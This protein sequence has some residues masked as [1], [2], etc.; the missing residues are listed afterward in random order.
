MVPDR[1]PLH[2]LLASVL[3][4]E[5]HGPRSAFKRLAAREEGMLTLT[6]AVVMLGF[7]VMFG[8]IGNVG[9]ATRE[10]MEVQNAADAAAYST[11]L[12]MARGMNAI[13]AANHMIG[14]LTA[15]CALH[16]AVGG[17]LLEGDDAGSDED[18]EWTASNFAL[19]VLREAN[20]TAPDISFVR[21][22][23]TDL[24]EDK[25]PTAGAMLYDSRMLLKGWASLALG[26]KALGTALTYTGF[27][28]ALG[29]AM[30][31]GGSLLLA[32]VWGEWILLE[33]VEGGAKAFAKTA[34]APIQKYVVPA[35]VLYTDMIAQ[36]RA[37]SYLS[38]TVAEASKEIGRRNRVEVQLYPKPQSIRLPVAA[39]SPPRSG[40]GAISIDTS[41]QSL[42]LPFA[43]EL[44]QVARAGIGLADELLD[45]IDSRWVRM[46]L[47]SEITGPIRKLNE[48]LGKVREWLNVI[49]GKQGFLSNP[50]LDDL[51]QMNVDWN[52][53]ASAQWTRATYPYVNSMRLPFVKA[54]GAFPG[55]APLSKSATWYMQWTSR[56]AI[57]K[58]VEFRQP[59]DDE[60]LSMYVMQDSERTKTGQSS[61]QQG[62]RKGFEAWTT[63]RDLAERL[64]TVVAFVQRD[65]KTSL[66]VS[67]FG[68]PSPR[69]IVAYSQAM[70]YNANPQQPG[71]GGEHQPRVG[72]DTL[73]WEDAAREFDHP[74]HP[75]GSGFVPIWKAFLRSDKPPKVKLNW[76]AKLVPVTSSRL[77]P[78]RNSLPAAMRRLLPIDRYDAS[79]LDA[80]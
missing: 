21:N 25:S 56:M 73:N 57:A 8:L 48:P 41:Y 50:S 58:A 3:K 18:K 28:S 68:E 1:H 43:E 6:V 5:E 27:G 59:K 35:L 14:E 4:G 63:D 29:V 62:S 49:E 32:E 77:K 78:G 11:A 54:L 24:T 23:V 15:I 55:G 7:M 76:Q 2:Q 72:W 9:R 67:I 75:R 19:K 47:P 69:T 34:K 52:Y 66:A 65:A 17:K 71:S 10:K 42:K 40:S 36:D 46:F 80:H 61:G 33:F 16:E 70:V 64:F 74:D 44:V 79:Q 37:L 60:G 26:V 53:E 31:I 13:T 30:Q 38:T 20:D 45:W 22:V 12:W 51:K 39:E